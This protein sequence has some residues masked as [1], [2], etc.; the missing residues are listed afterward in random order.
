MSFIEELGRGDE[1]LLDGTF[2]STPAPFKQTITI[3]RR[4]QD[5]HKTIPV[6]YCLLPSKE[7]Q[8]Y[9]NM[10]NEVVF[11]LNPILQHLD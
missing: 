4:F 7:K 6:F 8:I 5:T 11:V 10:L 2:T 1:W 9:I 3:H